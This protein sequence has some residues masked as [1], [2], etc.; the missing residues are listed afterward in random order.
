MWVQMAGTEKGMRGS[1]KTHGCPLPYEHI[2]LQGK[3][4]PPSL[5]RIVCLTGLVLALET[6]PD[7]SSI[8]LFAGVN[9]TFD[10]CVCCLTSWPRNRFIICRSMTKNLSFVHFLHP[11]T[12][13]NV[14]R[15][16]SIT[17]TLSRCRSFCSHIC[18]HTAG[19]GAGE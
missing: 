2:C 19:G 17:S 15:Q 8:I 10:L 3:G 12:S 1:L 13:Q 11:N 16:R 6:D 18:R 4:S 5:E 9:Y 14:G 7:S